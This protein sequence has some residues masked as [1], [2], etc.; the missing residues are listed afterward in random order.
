MNSDGL[1]LIAPGKN[2]ERIC[3]VP[4]GARCKLLWLRLAPNLTGD[5]L[6]KVLQVEYSVAKWHNITNGVNR[7][8]APSRIDILKPIFQ[9]LESLH[10]KDYIN[11]DVSKSWQY[12]LPNHCQLRRLW[13]CLIIL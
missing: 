8:V 12:I 2:F 5:G 9:A 7:G 6:P 3:A 11:S 4:G 10:L 1:S 13:I